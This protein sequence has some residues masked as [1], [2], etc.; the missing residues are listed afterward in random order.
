MSL[1]EQKKKASYL[2]IQLVNNFYYLI[3][4][5][6]IFISN[7]NLSMPPKKNSQIATNS[8]ISIH[9]TSSSDDHDDENLENDANYKQMICASLQYILIQS[10]KSQI[11]KRLDWINTV[12]RPMALDGRK[13]FPSVHKK[14]VKALNETFGY[15]LV[16][17][18]K[19]DGKQ[20]NT[21][22]FNIQKKNVFFSS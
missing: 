3:T 18:D 10:S 14:V 22:I 5:T 16:F 21:Q 13:Y 15:K 17:D 9:N 2:K 4:K 20:K 11:I 8:Q 19:H 12:L 1:I 6:I 7:E